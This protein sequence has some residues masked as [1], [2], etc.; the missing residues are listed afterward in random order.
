M[1]IGFKKPGW[2]KVDGEY[3]GSSVKDLRNALD[4]EGDYLQY[5]V[6]DYFNDNISSGDLVSDAF[7]G[8]IHTKED[9]IAE[10]M[11][12]I[13]LGCDFH[14]DDLTF[15]WINNATRW[16][17]IVKPTKKDTKRTVKN[18]TKKRGQK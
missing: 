17:Q 15:Y 6:E 12:Q 14:Y 9:Y 8:F 10:W 4:A 3:I 5:A 13:D 18:N 16:E 2:Y 1:T 11:E 7:Y